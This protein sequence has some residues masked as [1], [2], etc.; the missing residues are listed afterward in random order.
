MSLREACF[1]IDWMVSRCELRLHMA[2]VFQGKRKRQRSDHGGRLSVSPHMFSV[3]TSLL[4]RKNKHANNQS[5]IEHLILIRNHQVV[6][7]SAPG[8]ITVLLE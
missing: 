8:W 6:L 5:T 3:M 2:L 1:E 7:L 4:T